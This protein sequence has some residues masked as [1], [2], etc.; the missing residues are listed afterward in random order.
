MDDEPGWGSRAPRWRGRRTRCS[1]T[2]ARAI[3][4]TRGLGRNAAGG[5]PAGE[6]GAG[7]GEGR[8]GRVHL[9]VGA[10]PR[11]PAPSGQ[12]ARRASPHGP[13]RPAHLANDDGSPEP[14]RSSCTRVRRRRHSCIRLRSRPMS[15]EP[16]GRLPRSDRRLIDSHRS[17]PYAFRTLSGVVIFPARACD[18]GHGRG[19]T[20]CT[21]RAARVGRV[22]RP[23]QS[24]ARRRT[25][26]RRTPP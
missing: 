7:R 15:P 5:V 12:H 10:A 21:L 22:L 20:T 23:L 17:R 11:L 14:A 9:W 13:A 25:V 1:T 16:Q 8:S 18:A 2:R 4:P 19:H 24:C 6:A 26:E 3:A